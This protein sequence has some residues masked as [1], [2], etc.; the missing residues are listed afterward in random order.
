M[1]SQPLPEFIYL[2]YAATTP[3]SKFVRETM[4]YAME[5]VWGNYTS[6]HQKGNQAKKL[7]DE[8]IEDI[9]HFLKINKNELIF[10]SGAT[11]S[12]NQAIKGV[13]YGQK[14]KHIITSTVEHKAVLQTVQALLKE[15]YKATFLTPN[16]NGIVTSQMIAEA[17]TDETA[18][19]SLIWV[20]NETGIINPVYEI[21]ALAREKKIPFHVDATQAIP[22]FKVDAS[23]FDLLSMTGHKCY[24]PKGVGLLYR[25]HFPRLPLKPLIDGSGG[26]LGLRSGTFPNELILGL[27]TALLECELAFVDLEDE[28]EKFT[29]F[30][31][32]QRGTSSFQDT[33]PNL[34][35]KSQYQE[36]SQV[37]KEFLLPLK[38]SKRNLALAMQSYSQQILTEL[39]K[40]GVER[41]GLVRRPKDKE[42]L[43]SLYI[44]TILNLWVPYVHA[45]SLMHFL[46]ELGFAKG[47]ACNSDSTL[48]SYVLTELGYSKERAHQSIRLSLGHGLTALDVHEALKRFKIVIPL[49]QSIAQGLSIPEEGLNDRRLQ[50]QFSRFMDVAKANMGHNEQIAGN[51]HLVIKT[52]TLVEEHYGIKFKLYKDKEIFQ[53]ASLVWGDPF[54]MKSCLDLVA[55]LNRKLAGL[56]NQDEQIQAY[57]MGFSI[58][59]ALATPPHY[60]RTMLK[61]EAGLKAG[62]AEALAL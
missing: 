50:Q 18:L 16:K 43:K 52:I 44:P 21:A 10:T 25:R 1:S 27:R 35:T 28:D 55:L 9:A 54:L 61:I 33:L 51:P 13:C 40:F 26:Q 53:I 14:K 19:I 3:V 4:V 39:N 56:V 24:G 15:G 17:I 45:D 38:K 6:P 49:L 12:I 11:E 57:I 7:I 41:N 31:E 46:P 5:K 29:K 62:L 20:N 47:S 34:K 30:F 2:D 59:K 23:Q 32:R 42:S 58:E 60:L 37:E 36:L 22:H 8:A 48:P